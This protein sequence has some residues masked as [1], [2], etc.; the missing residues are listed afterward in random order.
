MLSG[1]VEGIVP[2]S[3]LTLHTMNNLEGQD[4]LLFIGVQNHFI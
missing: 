1:F 2:L 4:H 3:T